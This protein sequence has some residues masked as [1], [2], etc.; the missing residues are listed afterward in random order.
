MREMAPL[1]S[2]DRLVLPPR[3]AALWR[4]AGRF[5]DD[6]QHAAQVTRLSAELFDQ[7]R[8][9][10]GLAESARELLLAGG[11]LHDIGWHLGADKHNKSSRKL[12][13]DTAL[14]GFSDRERALIALLARYHRGAMPKDRHRRFS[15]LDATDRDL[16]RKLAAILR[17]A[18]GLDRTH[19]S[20]VEEVRLE[21]EGNGFRLHVSARGGAQAERYAAI[22]KADLF[23]EVYGPLAIEVSGQ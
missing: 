18:D 22:D 15:A 8:P 10:H 17:V 13:E 7:L 5:D 20:V 19:R 12:I 4:I 21:P 6:Q 14:P 16:V 1:P 11:I 2:R 23:V 3:V 9:H